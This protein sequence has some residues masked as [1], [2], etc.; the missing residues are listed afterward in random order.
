MNGPIVTADS[1]GAR[2]RRW[3][4]LVLREAREAGVPVRYG[5]RAWLGLHPQDPRR[6]AALVLAAECWREHC[7]PVNI[8]LEVL[9]DL[10]H[11]RGELLQ[12]SHD[13]A[14]AA[15]WRAVAERPTAAELRRR[16]EAA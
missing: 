3:A 6:L 13:V 2:T 16:R 14:A 8:A 5:E 1:Y 9:D 12:A 7:D 4:Q 11:R 10:V 15:D